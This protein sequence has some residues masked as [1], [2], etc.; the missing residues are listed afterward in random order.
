MSLGVGPEVSKA[1]AGYI[2]FLCLLAADL[3]VELSAT[4]CA[5]MLP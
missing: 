3:D 2:V 4:M 5:W 1:K